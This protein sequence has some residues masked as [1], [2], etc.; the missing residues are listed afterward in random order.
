MND[1]RWVA[2]AMTISACGGASV[3][4]TERSVVSP[5][6]TPERTTQDERC[7][8]AA[9]ERDVDVTVGSITFGVR[10]ARATLRPGS[11]TQHMDAA[12]EGSLR[13]VGTAAA[14]GFRTTREVELDGFG[15]L[16]QGLPVRSIV[17]R[18]SSIVPTIVLHWMAPPSDS[19]Y[20]VGR[21]GHSVHIELPEM[22]CD[23]IA[24]TREI[25]P[26]REA[27]MSGDFG[28]GPAELSLFTE[29]GS[30]RSLRLSAS[31]A[32]ALFLRERRGE[33]T[34]VEVPSV[35]EP[36]IG[37]WVQSSLLSANAPPESERFAAIAQW[38]GPR[39]G[40]SIDPPAIRGIARVRPGA[41]VFAAPRSGPWAT[42]ANGERF[43]VRMSEPNDEWVLVEAAPDA[44]VE[45]QRGG[46][47]DDHGTERAWIRRSDILSFERAGSP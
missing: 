29:P 19:P 44:R 14:T 18:G 5:R 46:G 35:W 8:Y 25:E 23:G 24:H 27:D 12:V 36:T 31:D 10:V 30:R 28:F 33:W 2:L 45:Y 7:S 43:E 40:E 32:V 1:V 15:A 34:R 38:C 3:E 22:A 47:C 17:A 6:R 21:R 20:S 11:D 4:A 41:E 16:P 26:S 39:P 42:V 37:G 13:F 9:D